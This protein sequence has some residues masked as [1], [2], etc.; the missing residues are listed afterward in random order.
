MKAAVYRGKQ[1]LSVEDV[2]TPEPGPG[3]VLVKV[4]YSAICGTDVHAFLYDIPPSGM[5]AVPWL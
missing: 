5:G 2:P 1:T 3:Q 4:K